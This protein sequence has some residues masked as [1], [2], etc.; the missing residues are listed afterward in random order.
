VTVV[1]WNKHR[2]VK[3]F[4]AA[5]NVPPTDF[6]WLMKAVCLDLPITVFTLRTPTWRILVQYCHR[7]RKVGALFRAWKRETLSGITSLRLAG[8][9]YVPRQHALLA[10]IFI[11]FRDVTGAVHWEFIRTL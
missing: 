5:E 3:E 1:V 9:K 11:A 8:T 6:H 10:V 7:G 4:M 2:A